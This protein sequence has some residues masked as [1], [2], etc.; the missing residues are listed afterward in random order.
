M[1][2][3]KKFFISIIM[4]IDKLEYPEHALILAGGFGSRLKTV[5][6]NVPKPMAPINGY[7]FLE[8]LINNWINKGIK[9]FYCCL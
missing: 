8:I 4:L 3:L 5:V 7:P 9:N 1:V 6:N 2:I